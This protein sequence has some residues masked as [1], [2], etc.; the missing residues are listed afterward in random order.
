MSQSERLNRMEAQIIEALNSRCILEGPHFRVE[1]DEPT[2][3]K[4]QAAL[5]ASRWESQ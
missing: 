3:R 1:I 4:I 2:A 5:A